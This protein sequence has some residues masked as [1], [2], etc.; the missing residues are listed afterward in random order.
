[1]RRA[2]SEAQVFAEKNFP[3][4]NK[5]AW[6][7]SRYSHYLREIRQAASLRLRSDVRDQIAE[8]RSR[9]IAKT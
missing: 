1:V 3:K 7:R 5:F 2:Q 8:V 9:V 4:K 6:I